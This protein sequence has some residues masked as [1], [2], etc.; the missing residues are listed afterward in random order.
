MPTR[1]NPNPIATDARRAAAIRR[2]ASRR[3]SVC[4]ESRPE[5]L[6]LKIEIVICAACAR[7]RSGKASVDFHHVAGEA[8]SPVT[9]AVP[10]NDHRAELSPAQYEWPTQT[11]RNP[12]QSPLIA[13]AGMLRGF[14]DLFLYLCDKYILFI[15]ALL[16]TLDTYLRNTLGPKWWLG[17]ALEQ[18]APQP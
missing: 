18:W 15:A 17:T 1:R 9:I 8:N 2:A 4:G 14:A 11:Q 3:C 5:A 16:E 13:A 6:L 12:E 10:V 7:R